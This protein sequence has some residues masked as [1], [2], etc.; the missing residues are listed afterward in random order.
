MHHSCVGS[1]GS[2]VKGAATLL[3][4]RTLRSGCSEEVAGEAAEEEP[5]PLEAAGEAGEA[6]SKRRVRVGV[7]W[8]VPSN[9]ASSAIACSS[10]R[11]VPSARPLLVALI[12]AAN[13]PERAST[14]TKLDCPL[15]RQLPL[16]VSRTQCEQE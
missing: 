11:T 5:A 9:L 15:V 16:E 13:A 14:P 7:H 1:E 3:R 2:C 8:T 10:V 12:P 4:A 6:G